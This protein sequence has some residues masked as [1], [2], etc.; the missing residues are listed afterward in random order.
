MM[1]TK[2][3]N[4]IFD[5]SSSLFSNGIFLLFQLK[6]YVYEVDINRSDECRGIQVMDSV[7]LEQVRKGRKLLVADTET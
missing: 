6:I 7:V 1:R 4:A 2:C 3:T 5:I